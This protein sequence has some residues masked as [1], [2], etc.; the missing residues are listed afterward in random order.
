MPNV[1]NVTSDKQRLPIGTRIVFLK[2][3]DALACEDHPAFL[4]AKKG[5]GGEVTGHGCREGHWVKWDHWSTPFGAEYG[6]DFTEAP[7]P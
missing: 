4:Y 5:Q 7:C 6:I 1:P 3:L 2:T